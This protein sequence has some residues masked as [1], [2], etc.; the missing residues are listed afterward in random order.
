MERTEI[1]NFLNNDKVIIYVDG[2]SFNH[3][4]F[5]NHKLLSIKDEDLN[6]R[7]DYVIKNENKKLLLV[8]KTDD[9]NGISDCD[10]A[11]VNI[12]DKNMYLV[13][14]KSSYHQDIVKKAYEQIL[15]TYNKLKEVFTG[16][17]FKFRIVFSDRYVGDALD[18]TK[19][20]IKDKKKDFDFKIYQSN[21]KSSLKNIETI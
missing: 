4:Y 18:E 8:L 13:E 16:F 6:S 7:S 10:Y 11:V 20:F 1:K 17:T 14:L 19:K 2:K 3:L 5:G 21:K 15:E 12:S 9:S